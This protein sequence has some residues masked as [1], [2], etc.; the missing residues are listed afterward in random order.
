MI[1]GMLTPKEAEIIH[2]L[3]LEKGITVYEVLNPLMEG[4]DLPGSTFPREIEKLSGVV[5]TIDTVYHF[6]LDWKDDQYIF[7][8]WH[9][10]HPDEIRS[11]RAYR[12]A[13]KRLR[14]RLS[15]S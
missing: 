11:I 1:R 15:S 14:Q 8:G 10:A 2:Q 9:E 4:S 6:W 13:Q 3:L 5:V 7:W 12:E